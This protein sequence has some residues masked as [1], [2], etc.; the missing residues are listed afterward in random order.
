M[1]FLIV[2]AVSCLI[3]QIL[4]SSPVPIPRFVADHGNNPTAATNAMIT[5]YGHIFNG[6]RIGSV[7]GDTATIFKRD[8]IHLVFTLV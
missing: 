4:D 6:V 8:A 5:Y 1:V 3:W 7:H 2:L